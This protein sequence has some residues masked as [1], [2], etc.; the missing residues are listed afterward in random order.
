VNFERTT[1]LHEAASVA[2]EPNPSAYSK[3]AVVMA[4]ALAGLAIAA[5]LAA[6]QLR[7][8][9]LPPEPLF[10]DGARRVLNSALSRALPVP[11]AALGAAAY[12]VEAALVVMGGRARY[13]S[14]P[15]VVGAYA[16]VAVLMGLTSAGLIVYQFL[17]VHA[18]CTLCLASALVSLLL[19]APALPEAKAALTVGRRARGSARRPPQGFRAR[20]Q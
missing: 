9:P 19:V 14:A 7:I 15:H 8:L 6:Y 5:R 18:A 4:F 13:A 3:R 2:R 16:A 1:S 11:D 17:V 10:G 12:A 20:P